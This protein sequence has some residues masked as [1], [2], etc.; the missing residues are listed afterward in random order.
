MKYKQDAF[1][2]VG[3]VLVQFFFSTRTY[4]SLKMTSFFLPLLLCKIP[5]YFGDGNKIRRATQSSRF[6]REELPKN[7]KVLLLCFFAT[8]AK[9]QAVF[10]G[11]G[12]Q[13]SPDEGTGPE[14]PTGI[15]NARCGR[16]YLG[17]HGHSVLVKNRNWKKNVG[18][19]S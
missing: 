17:V 5:A 6:Q 3:T 16:H 10:C 7:S 13:S 2:F 9:G 14:T 15:V 12:I 4:V 19:G 8:D 1:S 11:A 18:R